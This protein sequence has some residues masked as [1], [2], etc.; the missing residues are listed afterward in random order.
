M[1]NLPLLVRAYRDI[2][3]RSGIRSSVVANRSDSRNVPVLL[4]PPLPP[5]PPPPPP[6]PRPSSSF[7]D[8][9]ASCRVLHSSHS[10]S[11]AVADATDD[12][13]DDADDDANFLHLLLDPPRTASR[14]DVTRT[15][16]WYGGDRYDAYAN[17]GASCDDDGDATIAIIAADAR[18]ARAGRRLLRRRLRLLPPRRRHS[19]FV[20][21]RD[22]NANDG[23]ST[24]RTMT[25]ND[26]GG[27]IMGD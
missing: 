8:I 12:D 16:G 24:T 4:L 23:I 7:D 2:R 21:V 27:F 1:P 14:P 15:G 11:P 5:S 26:D 22:A 20:D 3:C 19:P 25:S 13:D 6:P 17:G 9:V 10:P 18:T